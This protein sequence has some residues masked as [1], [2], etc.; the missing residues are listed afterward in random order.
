MTRSAGPGGPRVVALGGGHGLAASLSALRRVT[1]HVTAVVTVAD[2]G[3]SSGRLREELGVLPPG[4]LRMALAALC[5]DDDWGQTWSKVIQHRFVSGGALH[6]HAMGN[7]L[8]VA[9]WELL[10]GEPVA[11]LDWVGRLL[12]AHGRV[13]PMASV[14]LEIT[15]EVAGLD[16]GRPADT[17]VVR[18]Q[19]AVATTPGRVISIALDPADPPPCLEAVEAV[20]AAD[21]VVFGPGSWFTSVLPHLLVPDLARA[22]TETPARRLLALNL[23][24]QPGETEGFSPENHLEVLAA[25]AP[26]LRLNVV[27]ADLGVVEDPTS[28]RRTTK[29]LGGELMLASV[30]AEDGSPQH[31]PKRLAE[32]FAHAFGVPFDEPGR[33]GTWR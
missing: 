26:E 2:D 24:P 4:D 15:A 12:G 20:R 33:S 11:A 19:V 16:P 1:N 25:H 6:G 10:G 5:G 21:W 18:G 3:G 30:A 7:L 13:L 22:L 17:S 9:L 28:L 31:D 32:A 27:L 23:A 29:T 8:I 14:P